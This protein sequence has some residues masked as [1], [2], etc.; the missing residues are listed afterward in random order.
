MRT[1]FIA[2]TN[3]GKIREIKTILCDL[4][5]KIVTMKEIGE[6]IIIEE[7]GKTFAEN[8]V[9]KATISGNE[10]GLLTL[11]EDSGLVIDA[12]GGEPGVYSSRYADGT[13]EG[14]IKKIF[15]QLK[16]IPMEKRTARYR[17]VAVVYDPAN[18]SVK[19]FEGVTEGLITKEKVGKNGFDYDPIFFSLELNKTFGTATD[20]EKNRVSHRGKALLKLSEFLKNYSSA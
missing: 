14:R 8:A 7:T 13:T 3:P 6:E 18:K 9:L 4:P 12:L 17:A 5:Y 19:T 15:Y 1:L 2:T 16:D 11:A 20:N 10:T